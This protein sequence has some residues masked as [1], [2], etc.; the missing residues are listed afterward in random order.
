MLPEDLKWCEHIHNWGNAF[1]FVDTYNPFAVSGPEVW[2]QTSWRVCPV[3]GKKAPQY[4]KEQNGH[5]AQ[6]IK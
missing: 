3:C 6:Q 5:I 1:Y 2:G 4:V